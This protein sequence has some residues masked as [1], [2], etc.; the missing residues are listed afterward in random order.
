MP[1]PLPYLVFL[2]SYL[3]IVLM[4]SS[5]ICLPM[6]LSFFCVSTVACV[7]VLHSRG[8]PAGQPPS[9]VAPSS[10]QLLLQN[11]RPLPMYLFVFVSTIAYVTVL[12]A[13]GTDSLAYGTVPLVRGTIPLARET[14]PVGQH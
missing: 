9:R 1:V 6:Y 3:Y 11:A 12:L 2:F 7:T 10:E 13:R 8:F 14:H 4:A 5:S